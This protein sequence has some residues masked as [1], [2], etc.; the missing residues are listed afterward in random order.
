MKRFHHIE[1][2]A[3]IKAQLHTLKLFL[4]DSMS[5]LEE[6]ETEYKSAIEKIETFS[7]KFV[8]FIKGVKLMLDEKNAA[9]K[10]WTDELIESKIADRNLFYKIADDITSKFMLVVFNTLFFNLNDLLIR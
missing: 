8:D 6:S 2:V 1:D 10:K 9:W 7:P 3:A 5:I 4:K